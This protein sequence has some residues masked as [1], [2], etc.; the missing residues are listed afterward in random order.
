MEGSL[1]SCEWMEGWEEGRQESPRE[2][3]PPPPSLSLSPSSLLS[4]PSSL[5]FTPFSVSLI[6]FIP[7]VAHIASQAAGLER[8]TERGEQR[9]ASWSSNRDCELLFFEQHYQRDYVPVIVMNYDTRLP[10]ARVVPV[11]GDLEWVSN[12]L[13][14]DL[15]RFGH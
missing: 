14:R 8:S 10:A 7:V 4:F 3:L 11:M 2:A 6:Y 12:H 13:F 1:W 9:K 15:E 5:G